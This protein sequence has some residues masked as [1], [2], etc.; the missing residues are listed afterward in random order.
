MLLEKEAECWGKNHQETSI[1]LPPH[2][3]RLE[4]TNPSLAG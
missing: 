3:L 1:R 2:N 4:I